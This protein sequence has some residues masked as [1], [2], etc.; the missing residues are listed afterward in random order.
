MSQQRR[1][2]HSLVLFF[3]GVYVREQFYAPNSELISHRLYVPNSI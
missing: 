3:F 1:K 2:A